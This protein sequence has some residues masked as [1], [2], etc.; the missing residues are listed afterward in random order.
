MN[1]KH[2]YVF[3]IT[4]VLLTVSELF[5]PWAYEDEMTSSRYPAG[6]HWRFDPPKVETPQQARRI[7]GREESDDRWPP[8]FIRV[9][10]NKLRLLAQDIAIIGF[11]LGTFLFSFSPRRLLIS[12]L[13][14]LCLVVGSA[15]IGLI[16]FELF[17]LPTGDLAARTQRALPK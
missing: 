6:Y 8:I 11:G 16:I 10:Q 7:V 5:P 15:A 17:F 2:I 13:A 1:R 9:F 4:A 12:I 3:L 14:W